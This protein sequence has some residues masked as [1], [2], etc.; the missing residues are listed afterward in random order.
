MKPCPFCG[1]EDLKHYAT[2]ASDGRMRGVVVCKSCGARLEAYNRDYYALLDDGYNWK[3]AKAYQRGLVLDAVSD[4]WNNR[5]ELF[6]ALEYDMMNHYH[7]CDSC[8]ERFSIP[9]YASVSDD[10]RTFLKPILYCPNC[11]RKIFKG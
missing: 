8:G 6:C 7:V 10:D 1:C 3:D 2:D 4:K 9:S 11:G 5:P